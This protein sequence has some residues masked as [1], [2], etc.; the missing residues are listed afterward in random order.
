MKTVIAAAVG[1]CVHVAGISNFLRYAEQIGWR[2]IFLGPAVPIHEVIAVAKREN[3]DMVGI[4]YRLTPENGEQLLARFAEEADELRSAGVRF[5]FG[6]TPPVVER[7]RKLEFF[8]AC[9]DGTQPA[10]ELIRHLDPT[11]ESGPQIAHPPQTAT[12]R[13]LHKRPFPLIRHHFGLPDLEATIDGI[14][15]IAEAEVLDVISLGIDQDAQENFFHPERQD[16]LRHGAGGVPV[17]TADDYRTL[18][19]ASRR[20]NYPLLRTYSGTDDFIQLAEMYV[21][22]INIAWA[23]VPLY[24]FNQMDGRGPWDLAG[25]IREHQQL[26]AWYGQRGIPVEANEAHHWG[27]RDAP[28]VVF[29]V[30]AYLAAYNAR[31]AGVK[32]HIVQMMF[33]SPPV[34]SA[35]MDLAKMRAVMELV[36]RLVSPDFRVW[37]Q[38]RTGLLSYPVDQDKA[39]AHLSATVFTQ[40][41]LRPDIIHVVGYPEADHAVTAKEVIESSAMAQHVIESTLMGQL[42]LT[43]ADHIQQR[44]AELVEEAEI[45]IGAIQALGDSSEEDPL[46]D[47]EVLAQAVEAGLMDAPQL[48]HNQYGKGEI[49]TKPDQRGAVIAVDQSTG[50]PIPERD[51]A[52]QLVT[53]WRKR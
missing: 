39:R 1:E 20:G 30:S 2:T 8:E 43:G 40:M 36:S 6:G 28:D 10:A 45:L 14:A 22:T 18:Y 13:I 5:L 23:A 21:E 50:K 19:Q 48:G 12:D 25:S 7:V 17:R 35:A 41:A 53:N 47:P 9:F 31:A 11:A 16:K 46:V 37:K 15:R 29:V 3:A 49:A 52:Q 4:S 33:N 51:R 42:D 44:T 34:T 38:T 26:M 24:W 27:M 32:D